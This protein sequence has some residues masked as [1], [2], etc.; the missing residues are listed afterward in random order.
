MYEL[1]NMMCSLLLVMI[2]TQTAEPEPAVVALL[3]YLN[4]L[5]R[6][7]SKVKVNTQA[8]L[9]VHRFL[10]HSSNGSHLSKICEKINEPNRIFERKSV[11]LWGHTVR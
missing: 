3:V 7:D 10:F 11:V 8:C 2:R 5:S 1:K 4:I 9:I 6:I